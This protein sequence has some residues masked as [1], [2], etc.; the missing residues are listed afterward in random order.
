MKYWRLTDKGDPHCLALV[1]GWIDGQIHYSRQTP[2]SALFTRN[3]QNIVLVAYN[4]RRPV[5]T[6][7]SF[8]PTP[9]KAVRQ[10]GRDA[11]ECALFKLVVDHGLAK[12]TGGK[13]RASHLIG[14][15]RELTHALWGTPVGG[16]I[17]FFDE[18]KTRQR[19]ESCHPV[20]WSYRMDDWI[21]APPSKG[22]RPCLRAPTTWGPIDIRDWK[23]SGTRGGRLRDELTRG[24][25]VLGVENC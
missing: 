2:G 15:A 17:T 16:L 20:G 9:G 10:D 4:R 6:W 1:D 12:S 23:W 24:G 7:V 11:I 19:R 8:R 18:E 25:V 21:D 22:G 14:E 13:L 5:A 3:G